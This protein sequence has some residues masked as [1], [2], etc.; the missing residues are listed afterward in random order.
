MLQAKQVYVPKHPVSSSAPVPVTSP[1]TER[2]LPTSLIQKW[3]P[4]PAPVPDQLP[5]EPSLNSFPPF[6]A[7][8]VTESVLVSLSPPSL[9]EHVIPAP[10]IQHVT[11]QPSSNTQHESL[12]SLETSFVPAPVV[13]CA[14]SNSS[15]D[16]EEIFEETL[17]IFELKAYQSDAAYAKIL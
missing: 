9:S 5:L 6:F 14:V 12:D 8:L 11:V 3:M 2:Q 10:F 4:H 17:I 15:D 7:A 16:V 13:F 1:I